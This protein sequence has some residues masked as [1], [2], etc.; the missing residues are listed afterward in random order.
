M[1]LKQNISYALMMSSD[2]QSW[3]LRK[4]F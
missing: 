3:S 2:I 4:T 1:H